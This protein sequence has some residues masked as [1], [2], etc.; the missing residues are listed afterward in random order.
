VI[1]GPATADAGLSLNNLVLCQNFRRD[2]STACV[3]SWIK[4]LLKADVKMLFVPNKFENL[5]DIE[6]IDLQ[7]LTNHTIP[8]RKFWVLES[9]TLL[10][11]QW[12]VD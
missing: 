1:K 10:Q 6:E 8:F 11:D 7:K 2:R 12:I 4:M 3:I 5:L 9:E